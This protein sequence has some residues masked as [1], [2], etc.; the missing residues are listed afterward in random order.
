MQSASLPCTNALS[1]HLG[2]FP[3]QID[4]VLFPVGTHSL[5]IKAT[6]AFNFSS[7]AVIKYTSMQQDEKH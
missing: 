3:L 2:T 4:F 7:E 6:D 1:F 5:L